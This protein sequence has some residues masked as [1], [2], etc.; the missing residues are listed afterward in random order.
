M[1]VEPIHYMGVILLPVVKVIW[2]ERSEACETGF[3]SKENTLLKTSIFLFLP[4]EAPK[5]KLFT[6]EVVGRDVDGS[7]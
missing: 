6:R 4:Q 2:V 1:V 3:V 5:C 7:P